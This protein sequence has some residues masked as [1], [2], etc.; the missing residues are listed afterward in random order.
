MACFS[1]MKMTAMIPRTNRP[2]SV[3]MVVIIL[4]PGI[5]DSVDVTGEKEISCQ[6]TVRFE[7]FGSL[8]LSPYGQLAHIDYLAGCCKLLSSKQ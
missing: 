8:D 4:P 1:F 3:G 7:N 6:S 2:N 5:L